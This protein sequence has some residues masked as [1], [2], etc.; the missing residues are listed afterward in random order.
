[1][2][3]EITVEQLAEKLAADETIHLIDVR[4][5]EEVAEGI[6]PEAVH[7]PLGSLEAELSKLNEEEEYIIICRSGNRSGM[8]CQFMEANGYQAAN[9]VG[10]MLEWTG[11]VK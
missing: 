1:M 10:G 2:M 8:A 9:V 3:K 4:E 11:E 6:I 7:I 5:D